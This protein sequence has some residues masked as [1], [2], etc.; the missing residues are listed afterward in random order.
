MSS[1]RVCVYSFTTEIVDFTVKAHFL[2]NERFR[3][4][5]AD[6]SMASLLRQDWAIQLVHYYND[7]IGQNIY[8][9]TFHPVLGTNKTVSFRYGIIYLRIGT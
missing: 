4:S 2:N 8:K 7:Q 1:P 3:K 9:V 5:G 6:H